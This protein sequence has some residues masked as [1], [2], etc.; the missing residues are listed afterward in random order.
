MRRLV[1]VAALAWAAGAGACTVVSP[2]GEVAHVAADGGDAGAEAEG[3]PSSGAYA[4]DGEVAASSSSGGPAPRSVG[5]LVSGQSS[6]FGIALDADNVY[7][8]NRGT[9][10]PDAGTYPGQLM[11]CAKAGCGG[12]PTVLAS[13]VSNLP[14]RL[15]VYG[16]TIY[17]A[18]SD[19]VLSCSTDGCS[20]GPT[21]LASSVP[22]YTDIAVDATGIYLANA[23]YDAIDVCPFAGCAAPMAIP[24]PAPPSVIALDGTNVF[25]SSNG[26][27]LLWCAFGGTVASTD[28][29]TLVDGGAPTAIATDTTNVYVGMEAQ[30]TVSGEIGACPLTGCSGTLSVVSA[31]LTHVAGIASDG[32]NVYYTDWGATGPAVGAGGTP[33]PGTG[34]VPGSGRVAKCSIAGCNDAPTPIA[35]YVNIP[36]QIAVDDTTVYWTDY[37]SVA[38]PN[39]SD[40]GRVMALP[41]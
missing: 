34:L 6:P 15:A 36:Q 11:K 19:M 25:F 38:D 32:T 17:W 18:A 30:G 37:G 24:T 22:N 41:K 16:G 9:Y 7:W 13:G 10:S 40:E 20:G 23:I 26:A 12:S 14:T 35:G 1:L 31:S 39:G 21:V 28:C 27:A 5:L 4:L 8:L 29:S 2:E 3:L 33:L